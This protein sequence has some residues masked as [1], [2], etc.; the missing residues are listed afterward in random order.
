M[1]MAKGTF[2]NGKVELNLN[3]LASKVTASATVTASSPFGD[4]DTKAKAKADLESIKTIQAN[5]MRTVS[6]AQAKLA[7]IPATAT[8]VLAKASASFASGS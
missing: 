4:A 2:E 8:S 5:V 6:G 3:V 7:D 1:L